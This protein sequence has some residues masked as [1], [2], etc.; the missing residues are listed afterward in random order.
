MAERRMFAKTIIDSDPFL[1]MPASSQA[2]YFHLCMRADDDGFVNNPK[3]IQR[4]VGATEDDLRLLIAKSFVLDFNSGVIV[5]KH[6]RIHNWIR[7]DRKHDT[8]YIDEM[9]MLKVKEN[10]AYTLCQSNVSQMSVNPHTEY[11]LGEDSLDKS[12]KSYVHPDGA[13]EC[14]SPSADEPDFMADF[15]K[16]YKPYPKKKGKAKAFAHYKKWVTDGR[17]FADGTNKL[18]R[19]QIWY[20]VQRYIKE[21]ER[22]EVTD[23]QYWKNFDTL[24]GPDLLDYVEEGDGGK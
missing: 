15:E 21:Q 13:N 7:A 2:L 22:K 20:A 19:E 9:S 18:T 6:W 14:D 24:L 1:D 10:G 5:I 23:Y 4:M 16:I 17:K 3:R 8:K 11:R 12:R